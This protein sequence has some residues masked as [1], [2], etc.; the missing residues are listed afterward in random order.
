M[1]RH[2]SRIYAVWKIYINI[3]MI[4]PYNIIG[5][6]YFATDDADCTY[7][8]Q[9]PRHILEFVMGASLPQASLGE[10]ARQHEDVR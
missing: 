4:M 1:M 9:F 7:L 10:L 5:Y 8:F 2:V 3:I 6:F